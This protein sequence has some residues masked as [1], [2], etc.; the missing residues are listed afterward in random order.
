M[1]GA[2]LA[3]TTFDYAKGREE[4]ALPYRHATSGE[5]AGVAA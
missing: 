2:F 1:F 5:L 4:L 3:Y